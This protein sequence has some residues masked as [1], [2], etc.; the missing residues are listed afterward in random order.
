MQ[1]QE[2]DLK[3]VHI[4]GSDNFFADTLSCNPI[5]LSQESRDQALKPKEL[6]MAKIDLGADRTL[7]RELGNLSGHQLGDPAI[8]KLRDELERDPSKYRDKYMVREGILF[9][10]NDR[11][12]PYWRIMLPRPLE[13]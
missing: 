3:I 8:R 7:I 1:L 10:K 5:G 2:Y 4:K 9:C 13:T 11:T 12:H 6:F